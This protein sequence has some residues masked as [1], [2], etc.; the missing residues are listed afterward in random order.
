[1]K[2]ITRLLTLITLL[3]FASLVS[4]DWITEQ[5]ELIMNYRSF[6]NLKDSSLSKP[7][8]ELKKD[9]YESKEEF[10]A[11]LRMTRNKTI[12]RFYIENEAE[13]DVPNDS[14]V[15][16]FRYSPFART[17]LSDDLRISS[18][19]G[20]NAFGAQSQIIMTRGTRQVFE[21]QFFAP[22]RLLSYSDLSIDK[23]YLQKNSADIVFIKIVDIDIS[24]PASF[25]SSVDVKTAHRDDI[26][27]LDTFI[28]ESVLKG[29]LV[30]AGLYD[31]ANK[32]TVG[33]FS[34]RYEKFYHS[35]SGKIECEFSG[36]IDY[37]ACE[38]IDG[39]VDKEKSV[40][41]EPEIVHPIY[42]PQPQYP[43]RA[44]TR[45][46]EGYA[47]ILFTVTTTG[48]IRDPVLIE[49]VPEGWGFGRAAVKA[50][51][52]LKYNP[53]VIDGQAQEMSGVKYK[54][55]FQMAR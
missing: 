17:H 29:N 40:Q 48:G 34:P 37:A 47:V 41:A 8:I 12:K 24:D 26:I 33:V 52:K 38:Q 3:S 27:P 16:N 32:V 35:Y 23:G 1:M 39:L 25:G 10:N 31:K 42:V 4:A 11:R 2:K 30:A 28:K 6:D 36:D 55:T 43:R 44:Q 14:S 13:F 46:K 51:N 22:N 54:F 19:V 50:A 53:F 15:V 5:E 7:E 18:G 9:K 45:G 49:E 20:E 21:D